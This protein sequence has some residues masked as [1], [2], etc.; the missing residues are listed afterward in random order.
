M[1]TNRSGSRAVVALP[2]G[3]GSCLG[4]LLLSRQPTTGEVTL[5]PSPNGTKAT[6]AVTAATPY[7]DGCATIVHQVGSQ[8]TWTQFRCS[9]PWWLEQFQCGTPRI[10]TY[11]RSR[12]DFSGSI[13]GERLIGTQIETFA[14]IRGNSRCTVSAEVQ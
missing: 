2:A 3:A 4:E 14:A 10:W 11:F 1:A 9:A 8:V 13:S 7:F 5:P 6:G 12:G